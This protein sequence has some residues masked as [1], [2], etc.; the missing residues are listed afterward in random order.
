MCH[1]LGMRE[2]GTAQECLVAV[3]RAPRSCASPSPGLH[4]PAG[5]GKLLGTEGR[6]VW[7]LPPPSAVQEVEE[8]LFK[9]SASVFLK[10]LLDSLQMNPNW[11][12]LQVPDG[13]GIWKGEA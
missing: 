13:A 5:L 1:R 8:T 7:L 11:K 9:A 12:V 2:M 6:R 4:P 3:P 10:L